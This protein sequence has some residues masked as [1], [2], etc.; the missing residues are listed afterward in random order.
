MG[1]VRHR[2]KAI[3][4]D[5][6]FI[7]KLIERYKRD[8][9]RTAEPQSLQG[10]V[11]YA[12]DC[13]IIGRVTV[14]KYCVLAMYP[15]ALAENAGR[16]DAIADI[17]NR[18]GYKQTEIYQTLKTPKMFFKNSSTAPALCNVSNFMK[19]KIK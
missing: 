19:T 12:L 15:Q 16:M 1:S 6:Y 9:A 5:K 10:L 17:E 8:A 14:R 18:T 2:R 7:S 13:N 11:Q 4:M 3:I